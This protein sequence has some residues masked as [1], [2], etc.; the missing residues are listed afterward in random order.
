MGIADIKAL[1]YGCLASSNSSFVLPA[2]T[3]FPKYITPMLLVILLMRFRSWDM[4]R[5]EK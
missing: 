3:I 2:S 1:V 5:H 4:K